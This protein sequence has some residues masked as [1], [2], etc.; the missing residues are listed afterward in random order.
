MAAP[1][2]HVRSFGPD[3]GVPLLALHGVTGHAARWAGLAAELPSVRV[4]GVD[5]RGH[6][7]SPWAPPWGIEQHVADLVS[8]L[9]ALD[10][11][12]AAVAGHSFGGLIAVHLARLAPQRVER[13]VLLDP[14]IGL[15]PMLMLER[16][17]SGRTDEFFPDRAAARVYLESQWTAI[18]PH[19]IESELAEHLAEEN[20]H[21]R[22]RYSRAA[23]IASWS[24][25]ARPA[26][27]PPAG[28]RT[29]LLP[30]GKAEL[31]QPE[32]VAACRAELGDD[33]TVVDIDAGHNLFLERPAEV[34]APTRAFLEG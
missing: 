25:I 29:L 34:A 22:F 15:D 12:R 11:E 13:L 19:E 3:D 33:L 14:A 32:W 6:G 21:F 16:A 24:E 18:P 23:I 26:V 28:T 10:L 1:P 7:R 30:A 2:L 17:E 20:G 4:H 8:V 31:V 9:D 27:P 5:L